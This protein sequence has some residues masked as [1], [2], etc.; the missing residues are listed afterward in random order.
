[1]HG[2]R[3]LHTILPVTDSGLRDVP[4]QSKG[5][6]VGIPQFALPDDNNLP[7]CPPQ[8]ILVY[9][10]TFDRALEF[11][12]P[13][14]LASGRR[15]GATAVLMSVPE[16]SMN[17]DGG[18]VL[19]ENHIGLSGKVVAMKA[20]PEAEPVQEG[21]DGY[22]GR[23]IPAADTAHDFASFCGGECIH[24]ACHPTEIMRLGSFSCRVTILL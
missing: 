5:K 18:V 13:I 7:S 4:V 2:P 22:L 8:I 12:E 19:R 21:P 9:F 11:R 1:M 10:V 15:S 14:V 24:R 20:K 23:R 16:T 3:V 17:E 6:A